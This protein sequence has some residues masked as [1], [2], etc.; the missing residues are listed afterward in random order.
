MLDQ[1]RH[2]AVAHGLQPVLVGLGRQGADQA[3]RKQQGC[4]R[5]GTAVAGLNT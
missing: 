1:V 4:N 3:M 2:V 5:L